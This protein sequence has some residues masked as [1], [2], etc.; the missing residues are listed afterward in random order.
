M[1][2]AR[3]G[4]RGTVPFGLAASLLAFLL[5]VAGCANG[6]LASE[7][8]PNPVASP[9]PVGR[10]VPPVPSDTV[11]PPAAG[12]PAPTTPPAP[13]ASIVVP[14]L[15]SDDPAAPSPTPS[16]AGTAGPASACTGSD[17]NRDYYAA[18]AAAVDWAVYCPVLPAGWYVGSGSYRLSGGGSLEIVYEGPS[19]ARLELREGAFCAD[20]AACPSPP[21][22]LGTARFG[23]RDGSL[24]SD[25]DGSLVL[26]VD[27]GA[28]VSWRMVGRGIDES[29]FRSFAAAVSGVRD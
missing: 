2:R 18:I 3:R 29:T 8:A 1:I 6:Q 22:N 21:A 27:P 10:S 23:D 4:R 13:V 9:D 20:A 12:T 25:V 28:A 11:A 24:G 14:P 26:A 15:V 19:G 16:A 7:D 17:A 5:V